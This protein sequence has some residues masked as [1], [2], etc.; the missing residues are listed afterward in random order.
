[1]WY[2]CLVMKK[3]VLTIV[4][5]AFAASCLA[6]QLAPSS[7]DMEQAKKEE[8]LFQLQLYSEVTEHLD[9][10]FQKFSE[11]YVSSDESLSRTSL[12][13]HEYNKLADPYPEEVEKL[14]ELINVLLS[15]V[16]NYFIYFKRTQRENPELNL[17]IAITKIELAGEVERLRFLTV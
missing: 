2:N 3:F 12:L 5:A 6:A 16:E 13:R 9:T 4:F 10:I 17:K 14:H 11:G 8:I 7:V 15:R 1:M